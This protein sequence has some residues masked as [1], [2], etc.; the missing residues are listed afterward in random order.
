MAHSTAVMP[1]IDLV[2]EPKF[3]GKFKSSND[4]SPQGH[5]HLMFIV[6]QRINLFKNLST[7]LTS[8]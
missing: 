8:K 6:I 1:A 5:S 7:Y 2:E 4:A 3:G